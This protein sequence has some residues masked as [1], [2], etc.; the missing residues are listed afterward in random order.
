MTSRVH[1]AV[2][3]VRTAAVAVAAALACAALALTGGGPS[4]ADK[5]GTAAV[6]AAPGAVAHGLIWD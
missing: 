5:A 2:R 3:P 4:N 1:T 6:R